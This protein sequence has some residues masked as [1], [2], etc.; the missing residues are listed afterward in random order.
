[1]N[2]LEHLVIVLGDTASFVLRKKTKH[3]Q[4]ELVYKYKQHGQC[5]TS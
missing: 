5:E 4:Y 3:K 1:M 2:I